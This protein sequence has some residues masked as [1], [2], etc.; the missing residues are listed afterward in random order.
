MPGDLAT[1]TRDRNDAGFGAANPEI[2][3]VVVPARPIRVAQVLLSKG[4]LLRTRME[5]AD[6]LMTRAL[7]V[8]ME[9][10]SGGMDTS[11]FDTMV[12]AGNRRIGISRALLA[13]GDIRES[14]LALAEFRSTTSGLHEAYRALLNDEILRE[15]SRQAVTSI[16]NSLGRNEE[17]RWGV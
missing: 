12:A 7:M 8:N 6:G 16:A 17:D 13:S 1:T 11:V 3:A 2:P 5:L 14:T 10:K 15:L 9:L 4:S